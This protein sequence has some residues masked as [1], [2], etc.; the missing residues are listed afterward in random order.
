M[1]TT[2]FMIARPGAALLMLAGLWVAFAGEAGAASA[3]RSF[4]DGS[5]A[6][7]HRVFTYRQG[8]GVP[9]FTDRAPR[10]QSYEVMAFTC[11]A[12]NPRSAVDWH[13]TALHTTKFAEP[14]TA[15]A[16]RHGVDAALIRALIHAESGFN[17]L[18]RSHKGAIGL[19]QLM[20]GTASDMG[21]QDPTSPD[22]NIEGGVKYLAMLLELF[23]GDITLAAAAYNAGPGNVNRY[24]G[25]PPFAETQTYVTR[26]KILLDRYRSLG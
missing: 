1:P 7:V 18:A 22:Q 15:A 13:S 26:V 17:P 16:R 19:M 12:C 10:D 14:I 9:A 3:S 8:D 5:S 2:S 20:P 11:Y 6:P 25:V 21:V 4:S 23:N 24:N